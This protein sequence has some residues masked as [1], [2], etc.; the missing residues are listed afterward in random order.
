MVGLVTQSLFSNW[1]DRASVRIAPHRLLRDERE[2]GKA[3]FSR[4]LMP[5][6]EHPEVRALSAD[7]I[8]SLIAQQLYSYLNFVSNLESKI[9][10][11]GTKLIAHG[12]LAF[13]VPQKVRLDAWKIYCDEAHHALSGFDLI[14]QVSQ[15]TGIAALPYSFDGIMRRLDNAGQP[16][17]EEAPHLV[18]LLQVVVFETVV[19]SLL[20]DI[21]RDPTVVTAVR[22]VV[23][24]HARDERWHHAFYSLFYDHLWATLPPDTR[25][26]AARALPELIT[27]CLAPDRAAIGTALESVG[28]PRDTVRGVLDETYTDEMVTAQIRH[29]ARRSIRMFAEH[30]VLDLPGGWDAFAKAGLL[31]SKEEE[32]R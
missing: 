8:D 18:H 15:G 29:A 24:D 6:L 13:P 21:P 7:T 10:N 9:V 11:R 5:Y 32:R 20:T 31:L 28:L 17:E 3:L 23:D 26:R 14:H 12:E 1:H 2:Q 25:S 4:H 27:A 30:D 19:T 22:E 16:L